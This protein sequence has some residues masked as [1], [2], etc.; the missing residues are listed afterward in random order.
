MT[1]TSVVKLTLEE[2]LTYDDGTDK[3]YEYSDG[4]LLE[5]PP[6]T[7]LHEAIITFLVIRFFLAIQEL[8]LPLQVRPSGTE[9][10]VPNQCRRPDVLVLTNEQAAQIANTTAILEAAPPLVVEVVSPESV[11]RDYNRKVSEYAAAGIPE[12]WIVDPIESK[13]SVPLLTTGRYEATVFTGSQQI[14]SPTLSGL[15][16]TAA[17]VLTAQLTINQ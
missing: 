2:Y 5:M 8:G 10:Q 1:S 14:A 11:D 12:Y 16:L 15:N 9:V 13:V 17:Q 3:R 7:G 6:A 4:G